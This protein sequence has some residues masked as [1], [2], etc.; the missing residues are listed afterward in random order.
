MGLGGGYF[1]P[2]TGVKAWPQIWDTAGQAGGGGF[3]LRRRR[4]LGPEW[5]TEIRVQW[6]VQN[7][8]KNVVQK[9]GPFLDTI[10]GSK[11]SPASAARARIFC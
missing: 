2:E 3:L 1:G 10:L 7:S 9:L 8:E 11:M 4:R 5:W 6:G